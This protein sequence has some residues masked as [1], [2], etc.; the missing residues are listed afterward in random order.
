VVGEGEE[1][2]RLE[3]LADQLGVRENIQFLGEVNDESLV[4]C[5]QQCDVFV[6]PNRE[7][8]GDFEGF[9]MV[10]VE[11]QACGKPVVAGASGGTRETMNVG[12]TGLIGDCSNPAFLVS[13]IIEL[14]LDPNRRVS[15][16]VSGR[17]WVL[18]HFDWPRLAK[19]AAQVFRPSTSDSESNL[20]TT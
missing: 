8:N 16:G 1:R 7:I 4:E 2:A 10:L 20:P 14:L 3:A 11:A 15:M 6:L 13:T 18:Q 9:G 12:M 5:Y 17:D 19:Q